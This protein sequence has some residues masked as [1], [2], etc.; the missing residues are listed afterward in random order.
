MRKGDLVQF[1]VV[2]D[3]SDYASNCFGVE[4]QNDW[5]DVQV[6]VETLFGEIVKTNTI[7][8]IRKDGTRTGVFYKIKNGIIESQQRLLLEKKYKYDLKLYE[9]FEGSDINT[10]F[11]FSQI[12]VIDFI[13]LDSKRDFSKPEQYIYLDRV[14]MNG[15]YYLQESI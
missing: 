8:H 9:I 2:C 12:K 1:N 4:P 13:K 15:K 11:K 3:D 10:L 14:Y 6:Y 5:F 7:E